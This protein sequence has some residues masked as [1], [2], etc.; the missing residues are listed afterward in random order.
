MRIRTNILEVDY[1]ELIYPRFGA[2]GGMNLPERP[3]M[4]NRLKTDVSTIPGGTNTI[5]RTVSDVV[6]PGW[7]RIVRENLPRP[8]NPF[9]ISENQRIARFSVTGLCCTT[10]IQRP[11]PPGTYSEMSFTAGG[12]RGSRVLTPKSLHSTNDLTVLS[13]TAMAKAKSAGMDFLTSGVEF[14]KTLAMVLSFRRN[15]LKRLTEAARA[16]QKM[17]RSKRQFFKSLNEAWDA[18]SSF[19][20]E[21]RFGWRILWYDIK[22]IEDYIKTRNEE[23]KFFTRR[24]TSERKSTERVRILNQ[25]RSQA[26]TT[27]SVAVDLVFE[28]EEKVRVGHTVSVDPA[29]LGDVN[30][31][32]TIWE[33]IPFSLVVDWF[34]NV[35]D[36]ILAF[37]NSSINTKSLDLGFAS[38]TQT[39]TVGIEAVT[40]GYSE[41][42]HTLTGDLFATAYSRQKIAGDQFA[43]GLHPDISGW[44]WLDLAT[45]LKPL[46]SVLITLIRR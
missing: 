14:Q 18:F 12:A 21:F 39:V 11:F 41:T 13:T 25:R 28:Y 29:Y 43:I 31:V 37:Q 23:E 8:S 2:S 17:C 34:F 45:L 16:F 32:N 4:V 27:G 33:V 3:A 20:L 42:W 7:F 30:I 35:Q 38:R 19:W 44:Q 22:A 36:Y 26:G 15:F 10:P 24:E 40:T 9:S 6:T 46:S 1:D 5:V